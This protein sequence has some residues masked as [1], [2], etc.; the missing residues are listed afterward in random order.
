[1]A[2]QASWIG[3]SEDLRSLD[4]AVQMKKKTYTRKW[5]AMKVAK[6]NG[7]EIYI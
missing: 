5:E 2:L 4:A 3:I 6:G 7:S 1:M